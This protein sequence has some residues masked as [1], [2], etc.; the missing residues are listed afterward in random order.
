MVELVS[1]LNG[2]GCNRQKQDARHT[3]M[4]EKIDIQWLH[5]VNK[6]DT[7]GNSKEGKLENWKEGFGVINMGLFEMVVNSFI[8]DQEGRMRLKR[9]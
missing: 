2:S 3:C 9:M 6:M 4:V 1:T 5:G 8:E 7:E